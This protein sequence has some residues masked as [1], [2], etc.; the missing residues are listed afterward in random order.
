M[1]VGNRV[2]WS[3]V[4]LIL[5][6]AGVLGV[7]AY[8]GWLGV[9]R[10]QSI[11]TTDEAQPWRSWPGWVVALVIVGGLLVAVLGLAI[12]RAVLRVRRGTPMAD[13]ALREPMPPPDLTVQ[14]PPAGATVISTSALKHSLTKDL[15]R[16]R[17]VRDAAVAIV[18]PHE[19]PRL[20]MRLSVTQDVE[21]AP[22]ADHVDRAVARFARTS[23]LAP[24]V[25]EVTVKVADRQPERVR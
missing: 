19:R 4:G 14:P 8:R 7:L 24:E 12:L 15:E 16:G 22:L 25:A 23:G 9:G 13:V 17:Q 21:M 1:N 5:L 3:I 18:G 6:A 20:V 11:L 10:N 2:L